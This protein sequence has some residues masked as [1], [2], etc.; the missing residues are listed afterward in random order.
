MISIPKA[1][2]MAPNDLLVLVA[3]YKNWRENRAGGI[4]NPFVYYCAEQF[5]K[6]YDPTDEDILDGITDGTNDGGVDAV[7]FIVDHNE[8]IHDDT[9]TDNRKPSKARLVILQVKE[10]EAGFKMT[11]IDKLHFFSED[12]LDLAKPTDD[13]A[14]VSKYHM[15]L[16]EIMQTFKDKYLSFATSKLDLSI[17]YLYITKGDEL[18]PDTKATNSR[19]RVL[20]TAKK[21]M[22]KA[23]VKFHFINAQKLL[24]QV[25]VRVSKDKDLRWAYP[26]MTTEDGTVGI[27]K[28]TDFYEFL[29][30]PDK[31]LAERLF[32][33][34]VR[35]FQQ[36]TIVNKQI[37]DSLSSP[38]GINFWLLNNGITIIAESTQSAGYLQVTCEDPQIVNGLQSSRAI[39]E[40][41]SSGMGSPNTDTR[42]ILVRLIETNDEK[43]RDRVIRATNSQNKMEAASL[44]ST[45]PIHHAI[46]EIMKRSELFYDRRKGHY[47]DKGHPAKNIVSV[48]EVTKAIIA[49]VVQRPDDARARAGN[50]LRNDAHY[51]QVFGKWTKE[52][53]WDDAMPLDAYVAC[54]K[55]VRITQDFLKAAAKDD[56]ELRGHEHNLR[57]YMAMYSTCS[58]L[59]SAHPDSEELATL[60]T[61]L[62]TKKILRD[63]YKPVWKW[64]DK[65]GATDTIAKGPELNKKLLAQIRSRYRE[66]R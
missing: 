41:F 40:H 56:D 4:E 21:H 16:R 65:L 57:F 30:E 2:T 27:V 18:W 45:D 55:I 12:L 22:S 33:A 10:T 7:Y 43:V 54:V 60:R 51:S 46:E 17:D 66:E 36:Y 64:Y 37:R 1:T 3:S 61:S 8:F 15:H 39:F 31:S 59:E 26:P 63:C 28:L 62:I 44:R 49:I 34:N 19:N 6:P 38:D 11:E 29:T 32:E 42:S 35:G 52:H 20:E 9:E 24:D 50:Y 14:L 58:A 5:L 23:S 13:P 47:K 48:M 25:N 53:G